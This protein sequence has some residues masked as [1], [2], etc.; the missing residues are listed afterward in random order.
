MPKFTFT[1]HVTIE[2]DDAI[3]AYNQLCHTLGLGME[4]KVVA[5]SSETF[6]GEDGEEKEKDID[7]IVRS[8]DAIE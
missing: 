7:D 4:E 1:V 8:T 5:W 3:L 2:E 6:W